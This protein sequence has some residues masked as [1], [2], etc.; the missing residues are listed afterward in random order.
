MVGATM[1]FEILCVLADSVNS[2]KGAKSG[3]KA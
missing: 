1:L 3:V 2:R